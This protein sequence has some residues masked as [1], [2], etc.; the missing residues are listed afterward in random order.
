MGTADDES[1]DALWRIL[2]HA[3]PDPTSHRVPSE[4]CRRD[5]EFVENRHDIS[6]LQRQSIRIGIVRFVTRAMPAGIQEDDAGMRNFSGSTY[7]DF[8]QPPMCQV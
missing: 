2:R 1:L 6:D 4:V 7:P 3:P 5:L 8:D